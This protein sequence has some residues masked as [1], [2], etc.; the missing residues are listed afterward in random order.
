MIE[1]SQVKEAIAKH[2]LVESGGIQYYP[3]AYRLTLDE[4]NRKWRHSM[5]LHDLKAN[6]ITVAPLSH[7]NIIEGKVFKDGRIQD[8]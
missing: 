7:I 5:E 8:L 3:V 4:Q 6:S 2:W 1:I